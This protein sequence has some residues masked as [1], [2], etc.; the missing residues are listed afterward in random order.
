[1]S[2]AENRQLQATSL[3]RSALNELMQPGA[4][5]R[6]ALLQ[7]MHGC[8]VLGWDEQSSWF[9]MELSG[10]PE[11]AEVPTYREV[12]GQLEWE[13]VGA[14][15]RD[16]VRPSSSE[17]YTMSIREP[18]DWIES[19][20][21]SGYKQSTDLGV[22]TESSVLRIWTDWRGVRWFPPSSFKVMMGKI[23]QEA[24]RFLS[25]A[26]VQ[27]EYGSALTDVWNDY[28]GMVDAGLQKL[29]LSNHL[30]SIESGLR[31]DN[32]AQWRAAVYSSRNLLQ[33]L[34]RLLWQD[35]RDTYAGIRTPQGQPIQVTKEKFANRLGAYLHQKAVREELRKFVTSETEHLATAIRH[36]VE[37]Q[38]AAHDQMDIKEVR[39]VAMATYFILGELSS[40]TD[41]EPVREYQ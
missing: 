16:A 20:A 15:L 35:P 24:F 33:D 11:G 22:Q 2:T 41:L 26:Y 28:R 5:T 13:P 4:S 39:S 37:R 7:A 12:Q 29:D 30:K 18:L 19:V 21:E 14:L 25:R 27:L 9:D 6:A 23:R 3:F 32:P 34:A 10:Y 38:G 31:S 17:A 1:M 8:T 40:W 36:L